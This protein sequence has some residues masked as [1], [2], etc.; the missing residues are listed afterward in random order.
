MNAIIGAAV[1]HDSAIRH[2]SGRAVFIDDMPEPPG[3]L[4]CVLGLSPH[5]HAR[6]LSMDLSAVATAPGVA[7]VMT[8]RDVPGVND[9]GPGGPGD[10]IFANGLVEY[11]GQSIFGVAATSIALARSAAAKAVIAYEVLPPILTIDDALAAQNFVLPN[12][13]MRRG[14]VDAAIRSAPHRLAGRLE[15]GGQEHFYLEGQVAMAVP[16]ED[17]DMVVHSSTQHPTEVQHLVARALKLS[18]HSVVCETRRMGGGFGGKESQAS[19]IAAAAAL[20][21]QKTGRPVK[22]RLDRDDDMILTGKRHPFRIDYE[23]GFDDNGRIR[24]MIFEQAAYCGYSPDLSGAV[25]DRA[26]FSADNAYFLEHVRIVSHRCKLN[27]VSHTAFRGFGGPQGMMGIEHVVD[28]IARHLRLDPLAVRKRKRN[29]YGKRDR[30]VTPY[31][32]TVEDNVGP[33]LIAQLERSAD[34]AKRRKGVAAFNAKHPWIKRGIA[35]TP[36]KFGTSFT[37][38]HMNQAGALAGC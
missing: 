36:V 8:A 19:L 11:A 14:D 26:M 35:L 24:G 4:H 21:A 28:E 38:T 6:I 27:T 22:H 34:Y 17:G 18:D 32:M 3:L 10:P 7:A 25:A 20:L 16:H 33:E 5:A 9:V 12:Q 31:G 1:P 29:L 2:V 30:N 37:L 15:V 13:T 23:V